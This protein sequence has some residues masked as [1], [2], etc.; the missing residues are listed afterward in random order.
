MRRA[1][2][3]L[4][5]GAAL[6]AAPPL[7]IAQA[8][9]A[10]EAG[11]SAARAQALDQAAGW[12][13]ALEA[14][15]APSLPTPTD[16]ESAILI[17]RGTP[18]ASAPAAERAAAA[19]RASA[20]QDALVPVLENLGATVTA[21]YRV[22]ID[23][24]AVRVPSG[25]L[26]S[27]AALPGVAAVV[28]VTFLAPARAVAAAPGA[29]AD[30]AAAPDALPAAGRPLHLALIDAG[31]DPAHP[32]L[33]G[34]VGPTF[35]VIGGADLVDG[36]A[37]PRADPADAS[38]AHGT[39]MA[40]IVLR[41]T[42]LAGIEPARV[43]RLLA[44]RVVAPEV[45]GG[46]LR[47]LARSD[48]VLA[49]L[50]RAVDPDGDGDTADAAE[51]ILLGLAA[52][53]PGGG[54]DPL[55]RAVGAA[56]RLGATVVAPA[57]NEGPTFA[58]PGSVGAL[59]AVPTVIA[60]GGA[61][62]GAGPR[63]ADAQVRVGAAAAV[64]GGLPLMGPAP[65]AGARPGVILRTASGTASGE[66][67]EDYRG[68]DGASLVR[69]AVAVVA[70]GGGS[71]ADKAAQAAAAGASALAVWDEGGPSTFAAVPGDAG[72]PIP[73]VGLGASQGAALARAATLEPGL[74][75]ELRPRPVAADAV[76]VAS[77][78]S[79]GPTAD[80][81]QKPDLVAPAVARES[82]WPGVG[83]DGRARTATLTGTSAAAAE[84]AALAVRL[85]ID[86]PGLGP[87]A[88]RSLLVQ[89]ARPLPG[90]SWQRQGAGVA[91]APVAAPALRVEPAIVATRPTRAGAIARVVLS[92]LS[93]APGR[94]RIALA[95]TG[96]RATPATA[97]VS[98]RGRTVIVLRL[99]ER[100]SAGR[101]V[102]R[103]AGGA[104]AAVARVGPARPARTPPD[105]LG[106]P[107]VRVQ[108]GL[109]EVLV[110]LG[111]RRR[112]DQR[113]R[114]ATLR[115]VRLALVPAAG[116]AP[117]PVAGAKQDG[118]W[119]AGT[120]RFLVVR[121]RASGLDVAPGAYRLRVTA[122]GVDGRVLRRESRVFTL[123]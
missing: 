120:Y 18:A 81:R 86:G 88:V 89:A 70:R 32:W 115:G 74:T 123:R 40:S 41:S 47:P 72:L 108:A 51:V 78:S 29:P 93:G 106:R 58:R 28:P 3:G 111:V 94:Y 96:G 46:R 37:D 25:R 85:R 50:E 7:A 118:A 98:A 75:V 117:L 20:R 71:I 34:G 27:L 64:L 60:V 2:L 63:T 26:E 76:R 11:P 53:F 24:V 21:R 42:A 44:Y 105:A 35:P 54:T 112:V 52:G 87:R 84:V 113:V 101:L 109:A 83:A 8:R 45:V 30:P 4:L 119:P 22:L 68:A 79:W 102:V 55:A 56:D 110:R 12:R 61:S 10:P 17:L 114:A 107:E 36:D 31:I 116:G 33:G 69:G 19:A 95:G 38:Q 97:S 99:P 5:A 82:A 103:D 121:R 90:V 59:A 48:R 1:P 14:H 77:F 66:A 122:R 65:E 104:L 92:D 67:P 80:G 15:R 6:L 100:G 49:A 9:P 73:V 39:Q 13:D 23:A 57:G 62:A 43:P 91:S 16:T